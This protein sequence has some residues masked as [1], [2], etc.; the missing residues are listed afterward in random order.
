MKHLVLPFL[1]SCIACDAATTIIDSTGLTPV[2]QA[3]FATGTVGNLSTG[4]A[5][6]FT[7]GTLGTDNLLASIG[8]EGRQ[9]NQSANILTLE[10]WSDT[11]NDSGT[12]GGTL[13]ATSTNSTALTLNTT[14]LFNFSGVTL[15]ENTVYT[16]HVVGTSP[17][18]G[19]VGTA[20]TDILPNSVLFQNGAFTFGGS[21][22]NGIDVSFN[23]NTIPEPAATMLG[24]VGMLLLL[25]RR[26]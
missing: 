5:W 3:N 4:A 7:T 22:T 11:D 14:S 9:A 20:A 6:T 13:I 16:V 26:R 10:L 25:R 21:A 12:L 19:L 23:V 1:L 15:A 18:F 24:A 8:L 17:G 2:N